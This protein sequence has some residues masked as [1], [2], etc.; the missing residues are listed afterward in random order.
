M[1]GVEEPTKLTFDGI[2]KNIELYQSFFEYN[3]TS[4]RYTLKAH[5]NEDAAYDAYLMHDPIIEGRQAYWYIVFISKYP[6]GDYIHE[7]ELDKA[8]EEFSKR[9]RNFGK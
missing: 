4:K 7:E 1:L 9:K 2:A 5:I 8:I 3:E 6:I